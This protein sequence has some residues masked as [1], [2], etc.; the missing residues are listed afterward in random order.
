MFKGHCLVFVI[1]ISFSIYLYSRFLMCSAAKILILV[2]MFYCQN[3]I[4]PCDLTYR[5][6][7]VAAFKPP[8]SPTV[9]LRIFVSC[10]SVGLKIAEGVVELHT[11]GSRT[12]WT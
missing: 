6:D 5:I 3:A 10:R 11:Q 9:G 2:Q 4:F 12:R 1:V 8:I 7:Y